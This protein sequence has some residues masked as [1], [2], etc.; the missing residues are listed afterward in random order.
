MRQS[1]RFF[2]LCFTAMLAG[3]ATREPLSAAKPVHPAAAYGQA[4]LL[5]ETVEFLHRNYVDGEQAGYDRLFTAALKGMMRELDPYSGYEPPAEFVVNEQARTGEHTGIGIEAVKE[6]G[7]PLLITAVVPDSPADKAGILPGERIF[8]IDGKAVDA[9]PLEECMK[10]IRGP[11]GSELALE[12][13]ASDGKSSRTAPVRRERI[14]RSSAPAEAAH[15]IDGD[16]GYLRITSFNSHTPEEA[17]KALKKLREEGMSR[18]LVIDL[19][20]NPGGLVD[21][22][23]KTASLFLPDGSVLFSARHRNSAEPQIVRSTAGK[24]REEEL[25]VVILMNPFTAS[26]AELFSGAL[27]D[28]GRAKLVGMRS[29]GK[30]T[31]LQV[32]PLKNG[33]ALRFAAGRYLTPEGHVIEGQGLRPDVPVEL[34]LPQLWK[35]SAQLMREPGV[36]LPG[37]KGAVRDVQLEAALKLLPGRSDAEQLQHE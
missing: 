32:L 20:N 5:A 33:G 34:E 27:R 17:E 36:V 4:G 35:L 11:V 29:F 7:A 24:Y 3:C 30:G 16:I 31:L 2:I 25:P 10:R 22:A 19:R 12:L 15:L 18:G 28:H 6:E 9:L 1:G 14:I 13:L 8:R 23:A 21:G 37:R 26:A